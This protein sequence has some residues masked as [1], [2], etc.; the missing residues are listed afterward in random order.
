MWFLIARIIKR[1][2][3]AKREAGE[4]AQVRVVFQYFSDASVLKKLLL[5]LQCEPNTEKE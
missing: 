1:R 2:K 4:Q 5:G 3:K